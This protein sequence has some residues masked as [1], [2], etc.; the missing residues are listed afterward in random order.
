MQK[1]R[2]PLWVS[3]KNL[4]QSSSQEPLLA[5][6]TAGRG[7]Q[8]HG[9]VRESPSESTR[10]V[11]GAG[12]LLSDLGEADL[13]MLRPPPRRP[14]HLP[15]CCPPCTPS[16]HCLRGRASSGCLPSS[17][18]S[19]GRLSLT[20]HGQAS[21][22][23]QQWTEGQM[24]GLE[25]KPMA[26]VYTAPEGQPRGAA[27]IHSLLQRGSSAQAQP[28]DRTAPPP[29]LGSGYTVPS[30]QHRRAHAA[31]LGCSWPSPHTEEPTR[32]AAQVSGW[33]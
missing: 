24:G 15:C 28:S 16:P 5:P 11:F 23:R 31:V 19:C 22:G 25:V 4:G 6:P 33:A 10:E 8:E 12:I 32:G 3:L 18:R 9:A 27:E 7:R 13:R 1:K 20:T 14:S 2:A 30:C 29:L 17:P 21:V 26:H